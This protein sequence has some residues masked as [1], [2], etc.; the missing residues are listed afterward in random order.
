M[1]Y[2]AFFSYA[3]LTAYTPGPNNVMSMSLAS[4]YGFKKSMTFNLGVLLGFLVVMILC[5]AFSSLLYGFIPSVKPAMLVIGTSYILWLAWTVWRDKPHKGTKG[6]ERAVTFGSGMVLQFVNV[7][8][9]LYGITAMS[10]FILPYTSSIAAL[11]GYVVLLTVIGFSGTICW[12]LFGTVLEKF[13]KRYSRIVN[14]IFAL[15]LVYCAVAM[16]SEIRA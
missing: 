9:I 8:V 11:A 7:K 2:A 3:F 15:L 16:I 1:N 10:S 5:A 12:A 13:F 4:R 14:V 6:R